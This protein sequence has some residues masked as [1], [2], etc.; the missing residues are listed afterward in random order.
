[1]GENL[2]T[3]RV[4]YDTHMHTPLCKHAVGDPEEYAAVAEQRGLKGIVV[5]CH[6]PDPDGWSPRVRMS[7]DEFDAYVEL[8]D[9]AREA[10]ADRLDVRLGLESD[11]APGEGMETW[12]EKLHERAPLHYVL[13][14]VHCHLP[15]YMDRHYNGDVRAFQI[16]YFRHLAEAAETGLYDCISHPDLVKNSFPRNWN[17]QSILDEIRSALDRIAATGVAMELNTSGRLKTIPQMNPG[18][19]ILA[20]M[21]A[22]DIPVVIGSDAHQPRRVGADFEAAFDALEEAGYTHT[23]FFLARKRHEVSIQEAR[24]SLI[25]VDPGS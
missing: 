22:R 17:P 4:L 2:E 20:E 21:C 6:N 18:P 16:T 5:T 1:M 24:G 19:L 7:V 11:F 8:V 9:R 14:S 12:L 13:G 3:E 23:C 10:L 15:Q 25:P